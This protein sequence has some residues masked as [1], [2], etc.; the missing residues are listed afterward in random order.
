MSLTLEAVTIATSD[1]ALLSSFNLEVGAGEMVTLMGPSGRGK[2]M[3]L[4]YLTGHLPNGVRA[5]GE[6]R[7]DGRRIDNLRPEDRA[8]GILFQ[9]DLLFPHMSLGENLMFAVPRSVKGRDQR[10][11]RALEAL[12]WAQL[13]EFF[14]R[15]VLTLSGGQGRRAALVRALLAEPKAMLLDE[16]FT[17][18]DLALREEIRAFTV[19][20]L[21]ERHIPTLLVTHDPSDAEAAQGRVFKPWG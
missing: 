12:A 21:K 11:L 14:D 9:D 13:D 10:R 15:H 18:L 16:P 6:V 2:T 5:T 3:L 17:A 19:Q 8:L 7:L 1:T 4:N 20:H